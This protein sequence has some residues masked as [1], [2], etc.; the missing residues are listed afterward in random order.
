MEPQNELERHLTE[1]GYRLTRPREAILEILRDTDCHPDANWIYDRVRELIPNISLG[2]VYR[3]LGI[4]VEAGL[5][6]QVYSGEGT[7]ARYDGDVRGHYH[8]VCRRC[9]AVCDVQLASLQQMEATVEAATG[10]CVEGYLLRFH[11]LCPECQAA[12]RQPH[13][14]SPEEKPG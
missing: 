4:L 5:V 11:G 9:G 8:V 3:T 10:F 14:S 1:K 2:T 7:Q 12:E 13:P 6:Q